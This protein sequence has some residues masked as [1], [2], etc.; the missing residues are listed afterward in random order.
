VV[1]PE[2]IESGQREGRSLKASPSYVG[3][4]LATAH[5]SQCHQPPPRSI[6]K[7]PRTHAGGKPLVSGST[8][9]ADSVALGE[10]VGLAL[11]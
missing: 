7:G 10:A 6:A 5:D 8:S 4:L 3:G 2:V 1:Y 9:V 11:G